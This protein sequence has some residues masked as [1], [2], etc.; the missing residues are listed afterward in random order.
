L[1][2]ERDR[3][4]GISYSFNGFFVAFVSQI[5]PA[6]LQDSVTSLE[7]YEWMTQVKVVRENVP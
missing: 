7:L 4:G 3:V 2:D 1:D 5:D 6:D